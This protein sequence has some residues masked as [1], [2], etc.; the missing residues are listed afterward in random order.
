MQFK[1]FGREISIRKPKTSYNLSIIADSS[2]EVISVISTSTKGID[3]NKLEAAYIEDTITKGA[4]DLYKQLVLGSGFYFVGKS[5]AKLSRWLD[6]VDFYSILD[7]SVRD[8]LIFGEFYNEKVRSKK[9][10]KVIVGIVRV[11]PKTID[12]IKDM[13]QKPKLDQYHKPI[14]YAQQTDYGTEIKFS[15]DEIIHGIYNPVQNGFRGL[16]I[17]E[18]AYNIT[19]AKLT[20]VHALAN[21]VKRHGFPLW[22]VKF[23]NERKVPQAD[24]IK[25]MRNALRDL[26]SKSEIFY[27]DWVEIK[28]FE[29]KSYENIS[30]ILNQ[31]IDMQI[32]AYGIPKALLF[33][34]EATNRSTLQTQTRILKARVEALQKFIANVYREQ[35]FKPLAKQEGWSDI[36]VMKWNP[37][38][39]EDLNAKASRLVKYVDV[40]IL[41]PEEAK[42]TILNIEEL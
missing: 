3:R 33:G 11:D 24:E 1:L 34:G 25:Q 35:L 37:I 5:A 2:P 10:K 41:S 6:K 23:G 17:V 4:V 26:N 22:G 32:A 42:E 9:A 38:E 13:D 39:L 19:L 16:G 40:G 21:S 20:I 36:P 18:P 30:T 14:G 12:Y 27:P 28:Q 7:M 31:Y 8:A 29:S 15:S